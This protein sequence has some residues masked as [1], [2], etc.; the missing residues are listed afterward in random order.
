MNRLFGVIES[1]ACCFSQTYYDAVHMQ[2]HKGTPTAPMK[3]GEPPID[4]HLH[5]HDG[6]QKNPGAIFSASRDNCAIKRELAKV[7]MPIAL[8]HHRAGNFYLCYLRWRL[9]FQPNRLVSLTGATCFS[10]FLSS[11]SAIASAT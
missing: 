8:G 9:S 7:E 2:H 11:I 1:V 6:V 4:F 10:S 3:K 5:G